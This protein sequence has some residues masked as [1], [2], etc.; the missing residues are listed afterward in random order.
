[1]KKLLKL[2]LLS[3]AL[4]LGACGGSS[5][6]NTP[7]PE[8]TPE[9]EPPVKGY[10]VNKEQYLEQIV[11]SRIQNYEA[12]M[13]MSVQ[14]EIA[15]T[16]NASYAG[17]KI[18]YEEHY[19]ENVG[20]I[21]FSILWD[22]YSAEDDTYNVEYYQL[23]YAG[24]WVMYIDK[25]HLFGVAEVTF[26]IDFDYEDFVYN[27]DSHEYVIDDV[28]WH[29][30]HFQNVRYAFEDGKLI[31]VYFETVYGDGEER[32]SYSCKYFKYGQASV[33]LPTISE[34][35]KFMS[36]ANSLR[37]EDNPY[38]HATETVKEKTPGSSETEKTREYNWDPEYLV[39]VPEDESSY[40]IDFVRDFIQGIESIPEVENIIYD[41]ET[42]SV[43]FD[44]V[45]SSYTEDV[46]ISFNEYGFAVDYVLSIE[47][48]DV[49]RVSSYIY[50]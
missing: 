33:T 38:T 47:A 9:P 1:M 11:A 14:E 19:R 24:E 31:S 4:L 43:S 37:K 35:A 3:P 39:W 13:E 23:D 8:P 6:G 25:V 15:I 44:L 21:Y 36:W 20:E 2:F 32:Q 45:I 26:R 46:Y 5:G 28:V 41:V 29:D 42:R 17:G 18:R 12:S 50:E 27:E 22:S 48:Y 7:T 10:K 30:A 34:K 40:T 16:V 49:S